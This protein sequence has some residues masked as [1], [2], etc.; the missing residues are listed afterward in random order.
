MLRNLF[1][2]AARS[3][4]E[5]GFKEAMFKIKALKPQAYTWLDNIPVELWARYTFTTDL[6]NDHITNNIKESF[7]N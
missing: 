6:K 7:N 4:T 1:W 5:Q 3:Y 2:M